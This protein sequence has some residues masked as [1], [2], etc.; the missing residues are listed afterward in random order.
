[1]STR[2]SYLPGRLAEY[3]TFVTDFRDLIVAAAPDYGLTVGQAEGYALTCDRF[4]DLNRK[5]SSGATRTPE[6]ITARDLARADLT[7]ETRTLVDVIQA[8]PAMTDDKRRRLGITV[9][10]RD[11]TPIGP[12]TEVPRLDVDSV[13]GHRVTVRLHGDDGSRR[14]PAGVQGANLYSFVGDV[15]PQDVALWKAEGATSRSEVVVE[16]PLAVAPGS[17]VW[18]TATFVNAKFQSGLACPPVQTLVNYGGLRKAA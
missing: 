6:V 17:R 18:L 7:D 8:W 10:K 15:P 3:V 13:D 9:P 16:F 4:L 1:M 14:K 2:R 12:P 11:R 5:S